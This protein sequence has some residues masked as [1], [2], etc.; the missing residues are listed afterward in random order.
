[1]LATADTVADQHFILI[2][3]SF[4]K[5]T[6]NQ[7]FIRFQNNNPFGLWKQRP[8]RFMFTMFSLVP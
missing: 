4:R 3:A 7:Y 2:D 1:M 5:R 6:Q 8:L